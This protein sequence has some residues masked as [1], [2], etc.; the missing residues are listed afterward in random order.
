MNIYMVRKIGSS[1]FF[2]KKNHFG[3]AFDSIEYARIYAK[4]GSA[5][6]IVTTINKH[7][8]QYFRNEFDSVELVTFKLEEIKNETV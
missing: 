5:K 6:G 4:K 8:Q 7:K 2:S 1:L 3:L